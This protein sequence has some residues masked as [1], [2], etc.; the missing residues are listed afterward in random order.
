MS[1]LLQVS[2][3]HSGSAGRLGSSNQ[4]EALSLRSFLVLGVPHASFGVVVVK[5]VSQ[6]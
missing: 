2:L 5:E 1:E 4:L 3:T 6:A